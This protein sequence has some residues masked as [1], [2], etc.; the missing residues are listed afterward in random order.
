M[1]TAAIFSLSSPNLSYKPTLAFASRTLP[2]DQNHSKT[3]PVLTS[4]SN[5]LQLLKRNLSSASNLGFGFGRN[6]GFCVRAEKN[7]EGEVLDEVEEA[8]KTSTMPDRF[9]YLTKE[10]PDPPV[11]WPWF[12]ALSFLT[13]AW[14]AVLWELSNWKKLGF[15]I[16]GFVGYLLKFALAVIYHFIGDPI[17]YL[18]MTVETAL[19][20]IRAFYSTIVAYAP[21][22]ELTAVIM[23][24]SIV[25]AI[26]EATVPHA[27][28]S[29]SL[30]ITLSGLIG[31]ATVRGLI[32]EPFFFTLLVGIFAF[33]RLVKKRD[34]VSSALPVAAA[35]AA[36][37]EPWVRVLAIGSYLALA[38]WHH[39]K[40]LS[41]GKQEVED[42]ATKRNLPLPLLG[43]AL[44]I[45]VR[46]AAKW[47]G[48]R[49]L[50]WMIV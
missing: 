25:L 42:V 34:Y 19:Y 31:Y 39:W 22:P 9:R 8:R 2:S 37:G 14:R 5:R 16:L 20:S 12:V 45:G 10:A 35:L 41:I 6:L 44:A 32:I 17:T 27:A 38:I 23:L 47:A 15:A 33:S 3:L 36:V 48:H 1:S 46:L 21:V 40:K 13:Y 26:G 7:G 30:L 43:I 50:T 49:H 24:S 29:Q 11:R 4:Y 28:S 18:I